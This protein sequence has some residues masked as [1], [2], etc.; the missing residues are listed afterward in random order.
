V[1]TWSGLDNYASGLGSTVSLAQPANGKAVLTSGGS[2]TYVANPGFLGDDSLTYTVTDVFGR[3]AS[4]TVTVHVSMTGY[5]VQTLS[6]GSPD[7]PGW[8]ISGI[9]YSVIYDG[10]NLWAAADPNFVSE[11]DPSDG[12]GL[13]GFGPTEVVGQPLPPRTGLAT[14]GADIWVSG[15]TSAFQGEPSTVT[16]IDTSSPDTFGG[17]D[18]CEHRAGRRVGLRRRSCVGSKP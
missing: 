14:D 4:A 15:N 17:L 16:E 5:V 12:A 11:I 8:E 6:V 3:T 9:W 1:P 18:L 2:F 7:M 10:S 13:G